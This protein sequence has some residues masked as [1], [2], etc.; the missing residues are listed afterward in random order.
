MDEH[1]PA[2]EGM[3][4]LSPESPSTAP[5]PAATSPAARST[6]ASRRIPASQ[7]RRI[8]RALTDRPRSHVAAWIAVAVVVIVTAGTLGWSRPDLSST[9]P[10]AST[11]GRPSPLPLTGSGG[12]IPEPLAGGDA[13]PIAALAADRAVGSV[14]Q[15]DSRFRLTSADGTPASTLASRL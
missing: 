9:A 6:A 12:P 5:D 10:D 2:G 3:T 4:T 11:S 1:E 8:R 13:H 14:V 15:L 7:W